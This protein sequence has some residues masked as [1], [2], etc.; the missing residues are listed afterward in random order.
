MRKWGAL[1][2]E[3]T[4]RLIEPWFDPTF[5]LYFVFIIFG[6]GGL[7]VWLAIGKWWIDSN[8]TNMSAIPQQISTYLIAIAA[9]AFVD[10]TFLTFSKTA[11][12]DSA[13][14]SI[15]AETRLS[16]WMVALSLF[17]MSGVFAVISSLSFPLQWTIGCS[18]VGSAAAL[19]IWWIANYGNT[20]LRLPS[21]L[22]IAGGDVNE[23]SGTADNVQHL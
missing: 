22:S 4:K 14:G 3:L 10:L 2:D 6:V 13:E 1:K 21:A 23:I 7:G 17:L 19:F 9:G 12:D 11:V 5:V 15:S 8:E 18:T 20:A 16:L